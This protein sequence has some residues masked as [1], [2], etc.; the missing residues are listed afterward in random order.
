MYIEEEVLMLVVINDHVHNEWFVKV[1]FNVR[2]IFILI[3]KLVIM[4]WNT[5]DPNII[6]L[7]F[8]VSLIVA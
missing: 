7:E 4:L 5:D 3:R 1:W 6:E 2:L 8:V